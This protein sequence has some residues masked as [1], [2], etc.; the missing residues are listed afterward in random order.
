MRQ[1]G[2]WIRHHAAEEKNKHMKMPEKAELHQ[3]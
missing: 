3:T 2:T 1:S